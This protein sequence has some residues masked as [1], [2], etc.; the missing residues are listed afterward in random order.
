M[1]VS[2]ISYP[3]GL[4]TLTVQDIYTCGYGHHASCD[5]II[6]DA[7]TSD[8]GTSGH[9]DATTPVQVPKTPLLSSQHHPAK[10]LPIY[11]A[12]PPYQYSEDDIPSYVGQ[13]INI[14]LSTPSLVRTPALAQAHIEA[15]PRPPTLL[16]EITTP[17]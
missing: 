13:L 14:C 3:R 12:L 6:C 15:A 1:Y 5:T 11:S 2:S 7:V 9:C 4:L 10:F 17:P 8:T 16:P